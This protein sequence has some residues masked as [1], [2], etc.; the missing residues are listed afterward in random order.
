MSPSGVLSFSAQQCVHFS[1]HRN[2]TSFLAAAQYTPVFTALS[3]GGHLGYVQ[4]R[5]IISKATMN[6][7]VKS[8]CGHSFHFGD[9]GD[10]KEI[11]NLFLSLLVNVCLIF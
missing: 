2:S 3:L 1:L 5:A 10:L 7:K 11:Y 4:F 6:I 9:V 8:L